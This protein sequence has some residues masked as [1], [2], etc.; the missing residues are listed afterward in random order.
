MSN[1]AMPTPATRL[2]KSAR[3]GKPRYVYLGDAIAQ[4]GVSLAH[5]SAGSVAANCA[6]P[7]PTTRLRKS[8]RYGEPR[9]V[10]LGDAVVRIGALEHQL[11]GQGSA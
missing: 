3:H 6:I 11:G 8:V 4:I 10:Y 2:R 9:Y 1:C 5:G 7:T